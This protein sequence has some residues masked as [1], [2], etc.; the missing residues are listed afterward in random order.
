MLAGYDLYVVV[1]DADIASGIAGTSFAITYS[2]E[3][4]VNQ[5]RLCGDLQ[6]PGGGEGVQWPGSEAGNVITWKPD[7]C[8]A[9]TAIG[10][11]EG[12]VVVGVFYVYSYAVSTFGIAERAFAQDSSVR[13]A[14]CDV[15]E[16]VIPSTNLG[17]V[18]F[19]GSTGY[20]PCLADTLGL[21]WQSGVGWAK[22]SERGSG[23]NPIVFHNEYG[24]HLTFPVESFDIGL[25]ESK[26]RADGRWAGVEVE[27]W[28][29]PVDSGGGAG[30]AKAGG[31]EGNKT[32][33][34][35]N[36][37]PFLPGG[38]LEN[39]TFS[40]T[41]MDGDKTIATF[42]TATRF[43]SGRR[44]VGLEENVRAVVG[45][46]SGDAIVALLSGL[47][48]PRVT[49]VARLADDLQVFHSPKDGDIASLHW[50]G[51]KEGCYLGIVEEGGSLGLYRLSW[52]T[53]NFERLSGISEYDQIAVAR[54][55]KSVATVT[56]RA[57][58]SV[59]RFF[60][61]NQ[62]SV[63]T[64]EWSHPVSG[65][66]QAWS[67]SPMFDTIVYQ[68]SVGETDLE[69]VALS[70]EGV[71]LGVISQSGLSDIGVRFVS[72]TE[73]VTGMNDGTLGRV[74]RISVFRTG[75]D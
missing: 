71:V 25:T 56:R 74:E 32:D 60:I 24:G 1:L 14:T 66:I 10:E 40:Y 57:G 49:G 17:Q 61:A 29:I 75:G 55:G 21:L 2:D 5:W 8:Q 50:P 42:G 64:E 52:P 30:Q 9:T 54:D 28:V 4:F 65:T 48:E 51:D 46:E 33:W 6:F 23:P 37:L 13:V 70:R 53:G 11:S 73:F 3:L 62:G 68:A 12:R 39:A 16:I 7:N 20:D 58:D 18:A 47:T 38:S 36:E 41:S 34:I 69:L 44:L 19:G 59:F 67:A 27:T 35:G 72:N 26:F 63:M 22:P 45:A 15:E 31:A 43:Y